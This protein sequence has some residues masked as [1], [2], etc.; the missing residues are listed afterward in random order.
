[1]V[2]I[3]LYSKEGG[4]KMD[5]NNLPGILNELGEKIKGDKILSEI[6]DNYN[7]FAE[8]EELD[9]R[10]RC[11]LKIIEIYLRLKDIC[12][13]FNFDIDLGNNM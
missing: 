7:Y 1:M 6:Y 10:Y 4:S 9:D 11:G 5:K 3:E 2:N 12:K 13:K 8:I